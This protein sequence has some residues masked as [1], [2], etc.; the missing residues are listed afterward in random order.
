MTEWPFALVDLA[1]YT[2]L[3]ET[4]GD[5]DSDF[6]VLVLPRD[7]HRATRGGVSAGVV[8]QVGQ[9]STCAATAALASPATQ[10]IASI[11]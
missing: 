10:S 7:G 6:V 2:A 1:G 9:L 4:H 8:E 3:T 5:R 11:L